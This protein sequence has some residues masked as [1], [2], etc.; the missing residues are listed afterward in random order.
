[1]IQLQKADRAYAEEGWRGLPVRLQSARRRSSWHVLPSRGS[2]LRSRRRTASS[3]PAGA[4]HQRRLRPETRPHPALARTPTRAASE[5]QRT[6]RP[7]IRERLHLLPHRARRPRTA[8]PAARTPSAA[9]TT[10]TRR[11]SA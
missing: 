1:S 3:A 8:P 10:A 11:R 2:T 5:R 4:S 9:A 6:T 7:S